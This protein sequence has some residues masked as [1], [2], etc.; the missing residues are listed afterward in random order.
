[1]K[2]SK[3]FVLAIFLCLICIFCI[4]CSINYNKVYTKKF[5]IKNIYK[6]S[7]LNNRKFLVLEL[8]TEINIGDFLKSSY[9]GKVQV[10]PIS[11]IPEE[12][13]GKF[14]DKEAII[15]YTIDRGGSEPRIYVKKFELS[16]VKK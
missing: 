6:K 4:A 8:D 3:L 2:K 12:F 5:Q 11:K 15:T 13:I 10:I 7:D 1:M 14:L 16:K 9:A